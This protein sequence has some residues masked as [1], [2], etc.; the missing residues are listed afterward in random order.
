MHWVS[1]T[2]LNQLPKCA[3]CWNNLVFNM[4]YYFTQISLVQ[5][6]F[7]LKKSFVEDERET[8]LYYYIWTKIISGLR[9][10]YIWEYSRL[11]LQNTV[12]SKR[13]LTWFVNEGLVDGWWVLIQWKLPLRKSFYYIVRII[14]E[15][16]KSFG[17]SVANSCW[18]GSLNCIFQGWSQVSDGTRRLETRHDGWGIKA[19]RYCPGT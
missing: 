19:I 15:V 1:Y 14:E 5:I 18:N 4:S 7:L 10:P 16:K 3:W 2:S 17:N 8:I 11:N 6:V 12:M 13:K 9:K